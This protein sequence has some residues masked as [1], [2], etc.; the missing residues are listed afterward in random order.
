MPDPVIDLRLFRYALASARCGSFR[1]AASALNVQQSTVSR[2]VRTLEHCLGAEL[3]ERWHAGVRPTNAGHR[4]LQEAS[5]G[6]DHL[7]RA[8]KRAGALQRGENGELT[9]GL[10]VPFCAISS[11]WDQFSGK[12]S[13]VSVEFVEGSNGSTWEAIQ[14]RK[15]D[16]AFL[17]NFVA[18]VACRYLHLGD[19]RLAV[20][21]PRSHPLATTAKLALEDLRLEH[22]V[23]SA[24][25]WGPDIRG[26]LMGR[27]AEWAVEPRVRL[28]RVDQC[29][30]IEMVAVGLGVSI[31]VAS[32]LLDCR[33]DVA[34]V[35]L[36]ET[37]ILSLYAI[38]MESN[39]NPALRIL[40][41]IIQKT[42]PKGGN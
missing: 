41:D 1:R 15:L 23:L 12:Y 22:F 14:Q 17:A 21:L 37:K 5:L 19:E 18:P 24:G 32:R 30:L 35:P 3:F 20:V 42:Y 25:G 40:L 6:M 4:F 10:S 34:L 7:E 38:W 8:M 16:I 36:A 11:I 31:A 2:G 13:G 26:Y 27:M 39:A 29:N 9:V 33:D 28:Q